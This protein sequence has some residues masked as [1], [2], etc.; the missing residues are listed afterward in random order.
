MPVDGTREVFRERSRAT[1]SAGSWFA[2]LV[3]LGVL[4]AVAFAWWAVGITPPSE[5]RVSQAPP[6]VT[7][8]DSTV[9]PRTTVPEGGSSPT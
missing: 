6:S 7:S 8:P 2:V 3:V 1:E 5:P 9:Q 4:A